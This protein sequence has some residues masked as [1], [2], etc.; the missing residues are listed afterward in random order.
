MTL[1]DSVSNQILQ[2]RELRFASLGLPQSFVVP[3]YGG[4][5]IVNIPASIV[6][7]FGG[8]MHTA[9]LDP[10]IIRP[11][12]R[13]VERVVLVIVD[14]MGYG[15]LAHALERNPD[16]GFH[17]LLRGGG[18]LHPLTSVFPSTT[19]AALTAL[20]SG[21]A[22]AEHGFMGY[23]MFLREFGVRAEMIGFN[24]AATERQGHEQ[25]LAGGL[26]PD[27]FL[28]VPSLPQ[29]LARYD[30]PVFN[31][32]EQ[33]YTRSA[34]SR[35]QIR[36]QKETRG[37]VTSTDMW[38]VLRTWLK[39][40]PLERALF[41]AYWSKIDTL[42]HLYG[43]S[44]ETIT[45]EIDNLA[46]TFEREFLRKLPPEAREGTLF[47]LTADHGQV[48]TPADQAIYLRDH[49][50]L[51]DRLQFNYTGD[52]RAPYLTVRNGE[53]D[54]VRAYLA[55]NLSRQ[56]VVLDSQEALR[57]GLFGGGKPAPETRYRI[58]DLILLPRG[59]QILWERNEPPRLVGRHGA[60][61]AQEML[62]PLIAARLDA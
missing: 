42:S 52:P 62:V 23:T 28:P 3:S 16:N 20:W 24:P 43:P 45:S 41:V 4:R 38:I 44:S 29:T 10:S 17:A 61:D 49:P 60:L 33:A 40:H 31:L 54:A 15:R 25:L 22:P 47:L 2:E 8:K 12:M 48:D 55:K 39:Q 27:S 34:L 37:F 51:R 11:Y 56:F 9:P 1:S 59:Q 57:A 53:A 35:V 30:V 13:G 7:M 50:A 58:G 46:Y 6:R 18:S 5:S 26:D 21:Y 19:T 36:G 14:A 32:I